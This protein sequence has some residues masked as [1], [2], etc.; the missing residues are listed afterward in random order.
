MV[1][2]TTLSSV[3]PECGN[4]FQREKSS[5]YCDDCRPKEQ[6]WQ[7]RGK[8]T[9]ERGYGARWQRLSKR[10]R[11]L[12]PFCTDCGR[13]D[14]LTADHTVEAWRRYEAGKSIRLRDI[15]V[16]CRDCNS[17]RGE[18]RGDNIGERRKIVDRERLARLD[19][20]SDE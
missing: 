12:Q 6:L 7:L 3:C 15:D 16:V 5:A 19:F 4:V 8:T 11:E 18:A 1:R 20:L 13:P 14:D 10:A 17:A 9:T 2:V